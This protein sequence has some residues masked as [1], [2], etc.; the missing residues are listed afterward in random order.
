MMNYL[1]LF[2]AL[3]I[4]TFG[5][6][7]AYAERI[8][9]DTNNIPSDVM[10]QVL[11]AQKSAGTP[12]P[13]TAEQAAEWADIGKNIGIA[14]SEA[15]KAMSVGVNEFAATD[16]GRLTVMMI[17]W[18][19]IGQDLWSIVGGTLAW[20]TLTTIIGN[21]YRRH[22]FLVPM[23][24]RVGADQERT[25]MRTVVEWKSDNERLVSMWVHTILFTVATIVSMIIVF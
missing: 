23:K 20:I 16:V 15:A 5:G 12:V 17:V 14:L 3:L 7:A 2:F 1:R 18:K 6:T 19:V 13:I 22:H 8:T 11:E 21:S 24:M 10:A 25:E 4:L 9:I